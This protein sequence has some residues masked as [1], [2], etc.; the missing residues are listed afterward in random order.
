MATATSTAS[1]PLSLSLAMPLHSLL[2]VRTDALSKDST[3]RARAL[4][5]L[6]GLDALAFSLVKNVFLESDALR[7]FQ[8]LLVLYAAEKE[9]SH[10]PI[11]HE[12][13][14]APMLNKIIRADSNSNLSP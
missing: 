5:I 4:L 9:H 6:S 11:C 12:L 3:P 14:V 13:N 7:D 2:V 10:L 8:V 1:L